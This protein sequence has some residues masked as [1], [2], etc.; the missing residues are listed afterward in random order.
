MGIK[1]LE[2]GHVHKTN[3][4]PVKC[5]NCGQGK[6][7]RFFRVDDGDINPELYKKEKEWLEAHKT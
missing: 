6:L 4:L 5:E 7:D 1:C 2:C 3:S